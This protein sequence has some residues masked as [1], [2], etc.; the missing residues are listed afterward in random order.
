VNSDAAFAAQDGGVE[1]D[2]SL[3]QEEFAA[4]EEELE[5]DPNSVINMLRVQDDPNA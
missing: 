1:V 5:D 3:F 4:F 2:V